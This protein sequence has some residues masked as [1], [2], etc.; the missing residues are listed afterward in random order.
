M[1]NE[2]PNLKELASIYNRPLPNME[3]SIAEYH[4]FERSESDKILRT[5]KHFFI[6]SYGAFRASQIL[7]DSGRPDLYETHIQ[8]G[9]ISICRPVLL[10]YITQQYMRA[11]EVLEE[12]QLE[13]SVHLLIGDQLKRMLK[14]YRGY[15][16]EHIENLGKEFEEYFNF[17]INKTNPYLSL[18]EIESFPG[19]YT[20][21]DYVSSRHFESQAPYAL[22]IYD[23]FSKQDHYG[24][25]SP[26]VAKS[27]PTLFHTNFLAC[28]HYM[29]NHTRTIVDYMNASLEIKSNEV[30]KNCL[31]ELIESINELWNSPY[32]K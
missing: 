23:L 2:Y 9:L 11:K 25:L 19:A 6:R 27:T 3:R 24:G 10:D 28:S 17:P 14:R 18:K 30:I 8:Q 22:E 5:F 12:V 29:M 4:R 31:L 21:A 32:R 1:I 7:L 26:S 20:M 16:E 15:S 13:H